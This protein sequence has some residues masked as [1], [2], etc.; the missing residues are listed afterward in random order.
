MPD[1]ELRAFSRI[2][3]RKGEKMTALAT[4]SGV[5][6]RILGWYNRGLK[7]GRGGRLAGG[8]TVLVPKP[9]VVAAA[10]D[11]PDPAVERYGSARRGTVTHVVKRGESLGL[12]AR[13]YRTSV[14]TLRRL[15]GLRKN[16][17]IPGQVIVVKGRAATP[18][19]RPRTTTARSSARRPASSSSANGSRV[20]HVVRRGESLTAIARRYDT[21]TKVLKQRNGL[22]GSD[23]Q[24]GQRLV[25][26]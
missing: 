14:A 3:T 22:R 24:I 8:I 13:R 12:L 11:V 21:T 17:I 23:I 25:V 20:V 18:A 10:L 9:S 15:N 19:R 4:R 16:L 26:R 1:S 6:A 5:S 2:Q 7:P